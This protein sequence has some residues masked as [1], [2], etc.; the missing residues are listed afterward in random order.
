M[1]RDDRPEPEFKAMYEGQYQAPDSRALKAFLMYAISCRMFTRAVC[2]AADEK[3]NAIPAYPFEEKACVRH[4]A[5]QMKV[6][7]DKLGQRPRK[8]YRA[9]W[10]SVRDLSPNQQLLMLRQLTEEGSDN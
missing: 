8:R 9:E 3:G 6:L 1:S 10:L 7:R 4:A 5:D 2:T